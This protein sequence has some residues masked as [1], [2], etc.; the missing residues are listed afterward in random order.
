MSAGRGIHDGLYHLGMSE[1]L[2]VTTPLRSI[3]DL[4]SFWFPKST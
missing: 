2:S 3:P 4:V 1:P